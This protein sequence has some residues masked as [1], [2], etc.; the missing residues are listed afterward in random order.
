M[1][2]T[3]QLIRSTHTPLYLQL[4]NGLSHLIEDE[5]LPSGTKLPSIRSLAKKLNISRDTVVSA[6]KALEQKGLAYGQT[7]RGTYV[8]FLPD[9]PT[10]KPFSL[11]HKHLINFAS[12]SLTSEH[13]SIDLFQEI[14]SHVL[15]KEKWDCFYDGTGKKYEL[16]LQAAQAYL[17]DCSIPC[18]LD[19]IRMV[20]GAREL[21]QTLPKFTSNPGICV[22]SP[23][24][25]LFIFKKYGFQPF[26]VPL[27]SDG[28][29]MEQLEYYLKTE[30]IQYIYMTTY[31]Q[32]PTGICYSLEKKKKL[33]ALA[34]LY[35]VYIIENDTFSD[36]L[37]DS[38][39]YAPIYSSSTK[40][41]VIYIKHFSRLYLPN[42][43][44]SF[45]IL[46]D[47]LAK[48]HTKIYT[49]NLTDSLFYYYLHNNIWAKGKQGLIDC[50]RAKYL[51]LCH[52]I[53]LHLSSY[54]SYTA[55]FGGIYIWLTLDTSSI[56]VGD[57]CNTLL[58][59]QV[60]IS[61]G[62]LFFTHVPNSSNLRISIS[63]TS[64]SQILQ[65]IKAMASILNNKEV[66]I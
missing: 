63:N 61:P 13:C 40:D 24:E 53:N 43:H 20:S 5:R 60:L 62:S 23:S 35:N 12:T 36:L 31:L 59:K 65:G 18:T 46:P 66:T 21:I 6:Y 29:D 14:T 32:N 28:M 2:N 47:T 27:K 1:F 52:L 38:C 26:E 45:V 34:K 39:H 64:M 58:N 16:L 9:S 55:A 41:H 56:T 10:F 19:Q 51:Y 25:D 11:D 22:E 57:L 49:Y 37:L 30:N 50:Y 33:L 8:S 17:S 54:F 4:A 44:Y 42:L 7:G 15:A 48:I 3:I